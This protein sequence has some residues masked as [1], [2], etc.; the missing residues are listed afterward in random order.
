MQKTRVYWICR[1]KQ[2][3]VKIITQ[4]NIPVSVKG[5]Y[6]HPIEDM[7]IHRTEF[8]QKVRKRVRY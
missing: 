5:I 3:P 7:D 8:M 1:D 2:C 4:D 6:N